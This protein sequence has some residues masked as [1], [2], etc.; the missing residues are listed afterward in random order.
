MKTFQRRDQCW[1]KENLVWENQTIVKSTPTT[2]P[3]KS[4]SLRAAARQLSKQY[5]CWNV[6]MHDQLPRRDIDKDNKQQL[7][8]FI[9]ENQSGIL[10]ILDGLDEISS[11]KFTIFSELIE[12]RVHPRCHKPATANVIDTLLQ[13]EGF[14]ENHVKEF[15]I[16]YFKGRPDLASKLS[17]R[18]SWDK[19]LRGMAAN[20]LNTAPL[21]ILW[22]G[23]EGTLPENRA[24][25][26]LHMVEC[27]LRRKKWFHSQ[28]SKSFGTGLNL[29]NLNLYDNDIGYAGATSIAKA[30]KIN[31]TPTNLNLFDNGVSHSGGPILYIFS[32][33][34]Q[35]Q[36]DQF[37]FLCQ[38]SCQKLFPNT[39]C[40]VVSF[41]IHSYYSSYYNGD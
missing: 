25:L 37:K 36:Q 9:R 21:C 10:L 1:L 4:K 19:N 31:K 22:D 39:R 18:M 3:Q 14:T 24:Q 8:Q 13:I 35:S 27:V 2:E 33:G 34:N 7:F 6:E 15:V 32:W 23:F 30:I 38:S 12:E 5:C 41:F 26:Y 28:L 29:I 11:S 40:F 17:K 20:P 16:K